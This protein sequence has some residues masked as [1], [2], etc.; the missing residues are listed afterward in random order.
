MSAWTLSRRLYVCFLGQ[1]HSYLLQTAIRSL[2]VTLCVFGTA[3]TL[4][5]PL[6]A[7]VCRQILSNLPQKPW[8]LHS[9]LCA[10]IWDFLDNLLATVCMHSWRKSLVTCLRLRNRKPRSVWASPLWFRT[11]A[12]TS[13]IRLVRTKKKE[14][15]R[16][17]P[18]QCVEM[19]LR[20]LLFIGFHESPLEVE[21][22]LTNFT[23]T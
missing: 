8:T 10:S 16:R 19:S 3:Q 12:R 2:P 7:S 20:S 21:H 22:D 14:E 4:P 5:W 17:W 11:L 15:N 6:C 1:T 13:S 18:D 23:C 9:G